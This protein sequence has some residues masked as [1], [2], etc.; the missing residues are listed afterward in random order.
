MYKKKT[1]YYEMYNI[2]NK[3]N[4]FQITIEYSGTSHSKTPQHDSSLTVPISET[5][6][7]IV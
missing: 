2:P 6:D 1:D 4:I 7:S 5:F 3:W